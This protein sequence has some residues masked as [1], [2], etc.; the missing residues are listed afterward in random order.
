MPTQ[1]IVIAFAI[2]GALS[3]VAIVGVYYVV[4]HPEPPGDFGPDSKLN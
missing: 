3:V 2:I 4:A 1:L